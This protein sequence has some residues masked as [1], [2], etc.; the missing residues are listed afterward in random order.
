[1]P[2]RT[3]DPHTD[4]DG[5]NSRPS[6]GQGAW[7]YWG[8]SFKEA[9]SESRDSS[10]SNPPFKASEGPD[11]LRDWQA[12][13]NRL[14]LIDSDWSAESGQVFFRL[15]DGWQM[16]VYMKTENDDYF[17]DNSSDRIRS[18]WR[19]KEYHAGELADETWPTVW[20]QDDAEFSDSRTM[21]VLNGD[22]DDYV[23]VDIDAEDSS[24]GQMRVRL[25]GEQYFSN[26]AVDDEVWI[27]MVWLRRW[28]SSIVWPPEGS[29][30]GGGGGGGDTTPNPP[31]T[32]DC[33]VGYEWDEDT[34]SC[35]RVDVDPTPEELCNAKD[36]YSWNAENQS[37]DKDPTGGD[38]DLP[39]TNILLI[40]IAI[41]TVLI[42]SFR[43]ARG[44]A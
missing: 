18:N 28:D 15:N 25:D 24:I 7:V 10:V 37:C 22:D 19:D 26:T 30:S 2:V 32:Y 13:D 23:S 42:I 39:E 17:E 14:K 34:Q 20:V 38:D 40:G 8:R 3:P 41:A 43:V 9:F 27:T 33:G 4:I 21:F 12:S 31:T 44:G 35:V 16:L 1:M 6:D 5:G 29:S 11:G 36:G